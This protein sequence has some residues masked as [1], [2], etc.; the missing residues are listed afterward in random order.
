[1]GELFGESVLVGGVRT[2]VEVREQ[3]IVRLRSLI[4]EWADADF[5][6]NETDSFH[7]AKRYTA[8][9]DALR[10]EAARI[11]DAR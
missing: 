11:K 6:F 9:M 4:T 1:M 2:T 7:D 8:A 5:N 10:A 3:E